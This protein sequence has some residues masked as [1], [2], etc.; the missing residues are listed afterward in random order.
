MPTSIRAWVTAV[1]AE[2]TGAVVEFLSAG[3]GSC[4]GKVRAA[5]QVVSA[6]IAA[7]AARLPFRNE[8]FSRV[9]MLDVLHHLERPI[10]FLKEASRILQPGGRLAMIE[11]AMTPLAQRFYQHFHEES[12]DLNADPF[13]QIVDDLHRDPFE[14]NQGFPRYCSQ[15]PRRTGVPS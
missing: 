3:R 8:L 7:V 9:V 14:A 15:R 2:Q 10:E 11:L 13:A 6:V 5:V 12:V 4:D 1:P